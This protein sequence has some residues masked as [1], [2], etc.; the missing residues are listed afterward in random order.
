MADLTSIYDLREDTVKMD[1]KHWD[2]PEL[3]L[4]WAK[5]S[6]QIKDRS[7]YWSYFVTRG[8][9][10]FNYYNGI[11]LDEATR[12]IYEEVEDKIVIEPRLMRAPIRALHGQAIRSLRSGSVTVESPGGLEP[13]QMSEEIAVMNAV[14]KHLEMN[15]NERA[16]FEDALHDAYVCCMPC[17]LYFEKTGPLTRGSVNG[18]R[19]VQLPWNSCLLGPVTFRDVAGADVRDMAF[20]DLRTQAELEDNFP[21]AVENIR[22]HIS[23]GKEADAKALTSVREWE[24][25]ISGDLRNELFSIIDAALSGISSPTGLV[26]VFQHL[27]PVKK[28]ESI[29]VNVS[30]EDEDDY[31]VRPR[32]W[33]DKR[34]AEWR[35]AHPEYE[36]PAQRE[37]ITLW[38]TAWTAS[39]LVLANEA[40]WFQDKGRLPI[41]VITASMVAGAPTGPADDMADDTLAKCIAEIE[42]LDEIRKNSGRLFA[43]IGGAVKN[44]DDFVNEASRSVGVIEIDAMVSQQN[45]GIAGV[46]KEMQRSPNPA[47]KN[48]GD[49]R[50]QEMYAMTRVNETMQGQAAPRQSDVAKQT[51]LAQALIVNSLYMLAANRAHEAFQNLKLRLIPYIYSEE[52]YLE[53]IDEKTGEPLPEPLPINVPT[54]FDENGDPVEV[55]NDLTAH[56]FK[57]RI[58]MIDDSPT[59]KTQQMNEAMIIINTA[60]GPLLQSDPSGKFFSD[61]LQ[62]MPNQVLNEAGKRMAQDIGSSQQA[63]AQASQF[64]AMAAQ[65]EEL[66][67]ALVELTKANKAGTNLTISAADLAQYPQLQDFYLQLMQQADAKTMQQVQGIQAQGQPAQEAAPQEPQQ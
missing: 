10:Y 24:N 3:A 38:H 35:E 17:V 55:L 11:I 58:S 1:G 7:D 59:A 16:R 33:S 39:G 45:G 5:K 21:D 15:S 29:W 48:W 19:L 26:P 37:I 57:W 2:D 56:D 44:I 12:R 43:M 27:F 66:R 40:H 4:L 67:K 25:I 65:Q 63:Q 64:E 51:E 18:Y 34:W 14:M 46:L 22:A 47:F 6:K 32:E 28:K 36:G 41:G 54:E 60:A 13:M 49:D 62:S 42:Y 53:M 31:V 50:A 9:R 20:F 52:D 30:S 23:A 8:Q 61:F